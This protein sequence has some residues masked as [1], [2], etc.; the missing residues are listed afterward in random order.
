[1]NGQLRYNHDG[2]VSLISL[3]RWSAIVSDITYR[4]VATDK[5]LTDAFE[6]RR[7]VFVHEQKVDEAEE[8]DGLDNEALHVI[9]ENRGRVIGTARVRFRSPN[10]AKIERM[11]VLRPFRRQGVGGRILSFLNEELRNRQIAHVVLHA[12]IAVTEFYRAHGFQ[13]KGPRF[14]EAGIEHIEMRMQ[15]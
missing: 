4:L 15:L 9:A 11:A 7:E 6:V 8:Y 12:Q 1:M 10:E 3:V 2:I 13:G 5:E 14:W